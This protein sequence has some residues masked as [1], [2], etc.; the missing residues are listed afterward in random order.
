M[1]VLAPFTACSKVA[2]TCTG[3][4]WDLRLGRAQPAADA[5]QNARDAFNVTRRLRIQ[6]TFAFVKAG[7]GWRCREDELAPVS[8]GLSRGGA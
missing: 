6:R 3:T 8:S 5:K 4:C 2:S 1:V 7:D